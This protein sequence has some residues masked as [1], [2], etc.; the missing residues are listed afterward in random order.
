[1][2]ARP[3]DLVP[4]VGGLEISA[5]YIRAVIE[6]LTSIGSSDLGYRTTGTPED[7]EVAQ[8]V[9]AQMRD[10]GLRDVAIEPVAVD[11][12]RFR[13]GHVRIGDDAQ[14][15]PA[16]SFGGVPGAPDGGITARLVD[17]GDPKRARLD[18]LDLDGCIALV[19]WSSKRVHP[20]VFVLELA[21]RG[22]RGILVCCPP[23]GA[24]F[25]GDGALGAFDG[26]WPDGAPP[27]LMISQHGSARL[28]DRRGGDVTMTLD[29][30]ITPGATGNNVV[31]YLR[32]TEP[33][34]IVVGAHHDA[35]F[36][37]AFDN[38]SGVAAMLAL[39]KAL[40]AAG[41]A[42]RHTICF[43]SRTGEE[44]GQLASQYDWCTG[45]W[46]QIATVHPEWGEQSPFHLCVEASGHP[47]L[48]TIVEAPVE[49][50]AWARS[51]C[52]TAQAQGWTPTGWRVAPPV[53]GTE[54]WPY[55]VQ[56]VPG[57]AAYAWETSFADTDYHTQLDTLANVDCDVVAAQA[58][59]YGL[60]LLDA[61]RRPDAIVDH[62]ARARELA[63]IAAD[64]KHRG[65]AEAASRHREAAGRTA[66]T[67]VGRNFHALNCDTV[68]GYPH[69]QVAKDLAALESAIDAI[70]RGDTAA[71][72]RQLRKVGCN[73]FATY[74]SKP[75]LQTHVDRSLPDAVA[76]SWGSASHLTT[77]PNLWDEI[78]ALSAAPGARPDDGWV[79]TS[80]ER[81]HK[82]T[83]REL[84]HRLD[85][86]A[87]AL[88]GPRPTKGSPQ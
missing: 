7:I 19:D 79:R 64:T 24:W 4:V 28:R 46:E 55:L 16:S 6:K 5:D 22:V 88:D 61:D 20:S 67:T 2:R 45:A 82:H 31:G 32:G 11:A 68:A 14:V 39:A 62:R 71:A 8:Y 51:V 34:P 52:R 27:M 25:Q 29:V 58:R 74:L 43:S 76:R 72:V 69:E 13:A 3:A 86:M 12:W 41:H 50:R 47:K 60:L 10:M 44:Y 56:G 54:Q 15:L 81:A 38:T 53:A 1:M 78:A 30:E 85:A 49:Y 33:G 57:V 84:Q 83:Q 65:L 37:G 21:L 73:R 35:W 17:V 77:S 36:Q 70:D 9:A 26:G 23:G 18:R 42:P 63:T 87:R 75:A 80:L 48:R 66:F 59:L 40:V